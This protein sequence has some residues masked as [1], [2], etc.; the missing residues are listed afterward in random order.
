MK[1]RCS[2]EDCRLAVAVALALGTGAAL[3][4][5]VN[6]DAQQHASD[7]HMH[8]ERGLQAA[9]DFPGYASLCD[10]DMTFRNVNVLVT[11]PPGT[12]NTAAQ[13]AANNGS[14]AT[15]NAGSDATANI[16]LE[17]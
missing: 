2:N 12:R 5:D 3:A 10:L 16:R 1:T 8:A 4:Q 15:S 6:G 7:A 9:E 11:D 14:S 13:P 17:P